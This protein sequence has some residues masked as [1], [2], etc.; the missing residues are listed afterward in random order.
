MK[1][2]IGR[3]IVEGDL[4]FYNAP[5][6]YKDLSFGRVVGFTP[7]M[8]RIEEILNNKKSVNVF[9]DLIGL[10]GSRC[11]NNLINKVEVSSVN[12]R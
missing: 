4:V 10:A 9:P 5:G 7:K 2:I 8:V 6:Y 3:E 11:L 12:N 1:D